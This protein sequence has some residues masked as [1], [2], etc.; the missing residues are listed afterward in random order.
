LG[1]VET[2]ASCEN[3]QVQNPFSCYLKVAPT[4]KYNVSIYFIDIDGSPL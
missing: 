3:L 2:I 4:P 1:L